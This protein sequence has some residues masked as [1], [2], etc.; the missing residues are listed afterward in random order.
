MQTT[1]TF[2]RHGQTDWNALGIIQ[3]ASNVPL[4]AKGVYQAVAKAPFFI[5]ENYHVAYSSPLD[6]ALQTMEIICHENKFPLV[7]KTDTR[8]KERCFGSAEGHHVNLFRSLKSQNKQPQFYESDQEIKLRIQSFLD[9]M[10]VEHS[11]K[12]ILITAHSHVLKT[13]L[14]L[15]DELSYSYDTPLDNL[16]FCTLNFDHRQQKWSVSYAETGITKQMLNI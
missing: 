1:L 2:I 14:I 4:N 5:E 3:G 8:L 6:R 13:A 15:I 9:A 11:G 10:P 16:A 7:I 12:N